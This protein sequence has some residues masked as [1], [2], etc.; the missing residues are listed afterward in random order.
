MRLAWLILT[1]FLAVA[2]ARD[3]EFGLFVVPESFDPA[4]LADPESAPEVLPPVDPDQT[5][6]NF[7]AYFVAS[8]TNQYLDLTNVAQWSLDVDYGSATLS[9]PGVVSHGKGLIRLIVTAEIPGYTAASLP[10]VIGLRGSA[11]PPED[12]PN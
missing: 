8:R 2:T 3:Q 5:G 10:V 4:W 11:E 7:R 6:S 1:V 12:D 9:G